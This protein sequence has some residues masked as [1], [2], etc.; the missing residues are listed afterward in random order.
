[1]ISGFIILSMDERAWHLVCGIYL[2]MAVPVHFAL[3]P[4]TW[5]N[6]TKHSLLSVAWTVEGA[7]ERMYMCLFYF[8]YLVTYMCTVGV[9][10]V[11]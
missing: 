9:E 3:C 1:M 4:S 7:L 5:V 6:G 2:P 11:Y 10:T 8:T